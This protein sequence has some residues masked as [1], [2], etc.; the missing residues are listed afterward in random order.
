MVPTFET[1]DL[2]VAEYE[3]GW[4]IEMPKPGSHTEAGVFVTV[5]GP[6]KHQA[7]AERRFSQLTGAHGDD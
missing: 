1:A 5:A 7:T 6:Y 2:S 3:D 4:V